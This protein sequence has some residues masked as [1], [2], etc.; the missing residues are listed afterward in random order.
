MCDLCNL[1]QHKSSTEK[2]LHEDQVCMVVACRTCHVPMVVFKEHTRVITCKELDHMLSVVR[3]LGLKG[4]FDFK[5]RTIK[6]HYHFHI[7]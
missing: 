3:K 4:K 1:V 2:V 6:D 7:R 5:Q